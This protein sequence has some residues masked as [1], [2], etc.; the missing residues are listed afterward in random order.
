VLRKRSL[1]EGVDFDGG[2]RGGGEGSLGTLRSD[3]ETAEGAEVGGEILLVL[4]LE[5]LRKVVDEPVVKVLAAQV[6]VTGGGLDLD[7]QQGH[8]ESSSSEIVTLAGDLL[9]ETV[10]DGGGSGLIDD[11]LDVHAGDGTGVLGS[12]TLRVVQVGRDN[13]DGVVDGGTEV[14]LGSLP[15]S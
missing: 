8:I 3:A 11:S 4:T 13:D 7:G 2:L 10:G 5:L 15:S 9:V 14:R 1:E 12:L 6:G